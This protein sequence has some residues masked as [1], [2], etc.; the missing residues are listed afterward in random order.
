MPRV[1]V[2]LPTYNRASTLRRAVGSVL[3]QSWSD[4]ELI[5]VDDGSTDGSADGLE[6]LDPRLTVVRRENGGVAAARNSGLRQAGGDLIAFID[7]DDE[8]RPYFLR[9]A[10]SFFDAFPGDDLFSTEILVRLPDGSDTVFPR[11]ELARW[12]PR[13]AARVGSRLLDLPPGEHDPYMRLFGRKAKPDWAEGIDPAVQGGDVCHYRGAVYSHLRWGYLI[14]LQATV[15]TRRAS[16]AAGEFDVRLRSAEDFAYIARLLRAFPLNL[17]SLPGCVKHEEASEEHLASGKYAMEF[18][19]NLYSQF[20]RVLGTVASEEEDRRLLLGFKAFDVGVAALEGRDRE[21]ALRYL[22]VA[23]SS[24][25]R[26]WRGETLRFILRHA[27]SP[28]L[29]LHLYGL[30][31][32]AER[33][34]HPPGPAASGRSR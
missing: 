20:E 32:L 10:C 18:R 1:S 17:V 28:R 34:W 19:E 21:K 13:L 29:T 9:L 16:L 31:L 24:I 25:D 15:M 2:V 4:F 26:F 33:R 6:S 3:A 7:S 22:G 11:A 5:V 8:W 23:C 27:R 12:Y 14:G 30:M